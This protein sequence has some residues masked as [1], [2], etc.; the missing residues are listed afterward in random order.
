MTVRAMFPKRLYIDIIDP[1]ADLETALS[2][3]VVKTAYME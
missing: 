3:G 2:V 1:S